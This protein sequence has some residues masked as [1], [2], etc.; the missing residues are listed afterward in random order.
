[1]SKLKN[2]L[3]ISEPKKL[4]LNP[5]NITIDCKIDV[6]KTSSSCWTTNNWKTFYKFIEIFFKLL[7]FINNNI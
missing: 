7:P 5:Q 2:I 1:M 4:I 3:K 6:H